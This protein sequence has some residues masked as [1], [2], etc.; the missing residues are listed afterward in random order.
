MLQDCSN[1]I[2]QLL[3][4]GCREPL[5]TRIPDCGRARS[6]VIAKEAI[7]NALPISVYS[8]CE[9]LGSLPSQTGE[10]WS[11]QSKKKNQIAWTSGTQ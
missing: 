2:A 5:V 1:S 6:N 7:V 8:G 3:L 10:Q 11:P 9:L 4:V